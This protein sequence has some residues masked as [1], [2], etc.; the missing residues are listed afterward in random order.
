MLRILALQNLEIHSLPHTCVNHS[1]SMQS[2][3]CSSC[4]SGCTLAMTF[5]A[6]YQP[7]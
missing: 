2:V 5:D 7:Q 6:G 4:S 3:T 1:F